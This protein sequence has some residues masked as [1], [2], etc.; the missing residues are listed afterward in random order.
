MEFLQSLL[1]LL[2]RNVLGNLDLV[3]L[4]GAFYLMAHLVKRKASE[5]GLDAGKVADLSFW[6]AVGGVVGGRL[7]YAIPAFSN[8]LAHPVD[9]LR[10]NSGMYFYGALV[11]GIA[12]GAWYAWR[13]RLP[14]LAVADLYALYAPLAIA[15]T[16]FGCLLENA[17]YGRQAAPPMGVLFPGLTQHRY[18]SDLYEGL[19]ALLLFGG[20]LWLTQRKP[21]RGVVLLSFLAGYPAVR[22]LI[23]LTRIN[24][25]GQVGAVDPL[26]SM[27]LAL[28]AAVLLLLT[29]R[30]Y[31][32]L[33]QAVPG[34]R[35]A[36]RRTH[37]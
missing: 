32:A 10:I 3:V 25:G 16:R 9:L 30:R 28:A 8:Y 6:L 31:D 33:G 2:V 27:A 34:I 17:C 23:D 35:R 15:L 18:P 26:L 36:Y 21:T 12:V 37:G 7:G 13:R 19:L 4:L 29:G 11:A 14:F 22:A 20:L 5:R 24:L 1:F